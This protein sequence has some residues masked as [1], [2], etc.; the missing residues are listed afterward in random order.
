MKTFS[1]I[2]L[3]LL[4]LLTSSFVLAG[5]QYCVAHRGN[6]SQELE[7]SRSSL[8]SAAKLG[9][10]AVEFDVHHTLDGV[11][12]I[13]HDEN[14]K[15]VTLESADCARTQKIKNLN[16]QQIEKCILKNGEPIPLFKDI[17][18]ELKPYAI[19]LFIEYKASPTNRDMVLLNEE[20]GDTPDRLFFISFEEDYL[21]KI[22]SWRTSFPFLG[23]A[24]IIRLKGV[25]TKCKDHF[26]GLDT[27]FLGKRH[28]RTM[29]RRG[30]LI[31]TYTKNSRKKIRKY[32]KRGVNF[33]TTNFP[34]KCMEE[35]DHFQE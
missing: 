27:M 11:A 29:R 6:S 2:A 1:T 28:V 7:N 26:D 34:K 32:F 19:K 8:I 22:F 5:N 21:N 9:V 35:L 17:L 25:A 14:L 12:I 16:Y 24:K 18:R 33:I 3:A 20:F 30:K 4:C 13:N 23:K 15:R 10:S 31:G